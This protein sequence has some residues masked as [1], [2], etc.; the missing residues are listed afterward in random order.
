MRVNVKTITNSTYMRRFFGGGGGV[1]GLFSGGDDVFAV[2]PT[3]D[4]EVC[5]HVCVFFPSFLSIFFSD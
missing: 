4:I 3:Y 2:L 1:F 5:Q